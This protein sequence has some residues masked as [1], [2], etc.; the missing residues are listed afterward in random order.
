MNK[1]NTKDIL[2]IDD[3]QII[4]DVVAKMGKAEGCSVDTAEDAVYALELLG[5]RKYKLILCDIMMPEMDGFKFLSELNKRKINIP[6]ITITGYSTVEN[7]VKSLSKGAIDF[8]PKPFTYDELMSSISRGL[9]YA[10][11]QNKLLNLDNSDEKDSLLYVSAPPKYLQLAYTNWMFLETEGAAVIGATDLFLK[12]IIPL[13]KIEMMEIDEVFY[14][15]NPCAKFECSDE[16]I[17]NLLAPIGGKIIERNEKVIENISLI[18]K[19]PYFEGWL[20]KIIP[21]D[22]EYDIK[23]LAACSSDR[24]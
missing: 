10:D 19:D 16:L 18:E 8:I 13:N 12:T 4:N 7:A 1:M 21:A 6:V 2:I 20:Y 17:H 11:I 9:K 5:K 15:G 3:E 24:Y 22:V 23:F 14:Q